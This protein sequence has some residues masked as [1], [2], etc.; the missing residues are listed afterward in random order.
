MLMSRLLILFLLTFSLAP[1][2]SPAQWTLGFQG[3]LSNSKLSGDTPSNISYGTHSGFA[4]GAVVDYALSP[5]VRLSMQPMYVQRGTTTELSVPDQEEPLEA[6]ILELDY[7]TV[8]VLLKIV[9]DNGKT[10]L[11]GGFSMGFLLDAQ[12]T[13][14]DVS[15]DASDIVNSFDLAADLGFGIMM[16]VGRPSITLEIRYEQ[17]LLNLAN[18]DRDGSEDDLPARF[19]CSGWQVMAGMQWPLGGR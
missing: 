13:L 9:A 17:S 2:T 12:L 7:F 10:Y 1:S 5:D 11:T 18:A 14:D 3:G 4:A 6:D 19:R 8:P 16:P 15:E